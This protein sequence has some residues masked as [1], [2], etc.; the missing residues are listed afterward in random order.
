MKLR[1]RLIPFE[2]SMATV[3]DIEPTVEAII[4]EIMKTFPNI[5]VS[6][7]DKTVHVVPYGYDGKS[8]W[9]TYSVSIDDWGV[10]GFTDGP[11]NT[12]PGDALRVGYRIWSV[13]YKE[14]CKV[15]GI[16][17]KSDIVNAI[18]SDGKNFVCLDSIKFL[19]QDTE[20][21]EVDVSE[22]RAITQSGNVYR[23][24]QCDVY[25]W[26]D[27]NYCHSCGIKLRWA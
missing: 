16:D 26:V 20:H 19:A 10:Y 12:Y 24:P 4:T 17:F 6:V 18:T 7:T 22:P 8:G 21:T 3:I 23:C 25:V 2:A 15:T 13:V 11:L 5:P 27:T 14:W 9:N 1:K